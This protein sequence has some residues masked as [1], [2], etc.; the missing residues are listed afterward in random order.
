MLKGPDRATSLETD[1]NSHPRT[2]PPVGQI[3][4]T[5]I[6]PLFISS[7]KT[8]VCMPKASDVKVVLMR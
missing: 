7:T 6:L 2:A 1:T 5:D 3:Q 8:T 4:K